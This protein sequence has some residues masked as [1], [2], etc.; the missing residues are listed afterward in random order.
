MQ[1]RVQAIELQNFGVPN[2]ARLPMEAVIRSYNTEPI[3]P[4]SQKPIE[5]LLLDGFQVPP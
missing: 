5:D 3:D 2:V 1:D 4:T